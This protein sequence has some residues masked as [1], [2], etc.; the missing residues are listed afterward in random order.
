MQSTVEIC[1][2]SILKLNNPEAWVQGE[3]MSIFDKIMGKPGK[4]T[5][6]DR[7]SAGSM[8][9]GGNNAMPM[10]LGLAGLNKFEGKPASYVPLKDT[11]RV[12][13][14]AQA[15]AAALQNEL[16]HGFAPSPF[17][18]SHPD[19]TRDS[20]TS[21][22]STERYS[23]NPNRNSNTQTLPDGSKQL[24]LQMNLGG[25]FIINGKIN[26]KAVKFLVDTG[27]SQVSIPEQVALSL[28]LARTGRKIVIHT[29]NG[30][31]D[32][33]ETEVDTLHI[34]QIELR[35]IPALINPGDPSDTIL[36]GM[37]ALKHLQFSQQ[38]GTL[39][40]QQQP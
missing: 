37:S 19:L 18:P 3:A 28:G 12:N 36:L 34:G 5:K 6:G 33:Y 21:D 11:A 17:G 26:S 9:S 10:A 7:S 2:V 38:D 24:K 25:S 15:A 14:M 29:A 22:E 8:M 1:V 16:D 4:E 20:G 39:I 31:V 40:L 32:A 35:F 23:N 30:Q 27:A 13:D